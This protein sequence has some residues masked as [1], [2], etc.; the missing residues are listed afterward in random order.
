MVYICYAYAPR[1]TKAFSPSTVNGVVRVMA[2][3]VLC[4]GAQIACNGL[5]ALLASR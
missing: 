3:I 1:L 4:I 2:F 5:T